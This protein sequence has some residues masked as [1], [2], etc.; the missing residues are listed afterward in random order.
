MRYRR[1]RLHIEDRLQQ[2]VGDSILAGVDIV[3][4]MQTILDA[5]VAAL[6]AARR[7]PN[8]WADV[9]LV[10]PNTVLTVC[11]PVRLSMHRCSTRK[12]YSSRGAANPK[13]R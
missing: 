11:A 8:A 3:H 5:S 1:F 12:A 9:R 4:P 6:D 10:M 2:M 13:K 7:L